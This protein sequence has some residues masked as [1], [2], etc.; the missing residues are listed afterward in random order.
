VGSITEISSTIEVFELSPF[1][2]SRSEFIIPASQN[3]IYFEA[4]MATGPGE[5]V[6]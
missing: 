3:N 2:L 1:G 6:A 5:E 4:K